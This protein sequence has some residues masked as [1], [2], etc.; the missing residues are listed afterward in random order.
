MTN[1]EHYME[2]GAS[3]Q[4]KAFFAYCDKLMAKVQI[5]PK[6]KNDFPTKKRALC[7]KGLQLTYNNINNK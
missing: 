1:L 5:V 2:D 6:Y 3:K 7:F 4:A